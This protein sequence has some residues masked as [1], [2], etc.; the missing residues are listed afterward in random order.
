MEEQLAVLLEKMDQQSEQLQL[1]TRQQSERVDGIALKQKE[2]DEHV[3]A[4][5]GD[6]ESVK[7][8]VDGRLSAVEETLTGLRSLHVE[9]GEKQRSLKQELR[10]ELLQELG[11]PISSGL[12]PTASPFVPS[13][14]AAAVFPGESIGR[15]DSTAPVT[16][17]SGSHAGG[18]TTGASGY[19]RGTTTTTVNPQQR[20]PLFDGK[21]PWDAYRTQFELLAEMNR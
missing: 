3:S 12:R 5:E 1:L 19:L 21:L 13:D 8:V 4:I 11:A 18:A 16:S 6:L 17:A 10:E 14:A 15:G 9:L 7:T 20:P 2:T